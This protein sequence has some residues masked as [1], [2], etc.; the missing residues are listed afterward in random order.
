MIGTTKGGAM[1]TT[2]LWSTDGSAAADLALHEALRVLEP[3]GLLIVFHADRRFSAG[4]AG[5]FPVVADEDDR[6]AAIAARVD[7]L[8]ADGVNAE[9]VVMTTDRSPDHEIVAAADEVGAQAIVCGTR[10]LGGLHGTLLG[11]VTNKLLR[12]SHVP[13]LVVPAGVPKPVAAAAHEREE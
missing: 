1:Y 7:Q 4:A 10:G 3:G 2:V 6:R 11:S 9:L 12:R 8:K 13:V 5:G